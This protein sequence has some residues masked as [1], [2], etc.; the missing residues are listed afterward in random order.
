MRGWGGP[1]S[2]CLLSSYV[3]PLSIC[4]LCMA[5]SLSLAQLYVVLCAKPSPT[6]SSL[7]S[8]PSL[9]DSRCCMSVSLF[10]IFATFDSLGG[11]ASIS[12]IH[13]GLEDGALAK[14]LIL[15]LFLH[16]HLC[17]I[18]MSHLS[19]VPCL[20]PLDMSLLHRGTGN[21]H[22]SLIFLLVESITS[23]SHLMNRQEKMECNFYTR[24]EVTS[25]ASHVMRPFPFHV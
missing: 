21:Q 24:F 19:L 11:K 8:C 12:L 9:P 14:I 15:G 10:S 4:L 18:S 6:P 13:F 2:C 17:Q 20:P 3:V 5:R 16:T 1:G 7:S 22:P 25:P 23:F